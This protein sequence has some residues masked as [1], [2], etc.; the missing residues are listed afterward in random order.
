MTP[1]AVLVSAF[2]VAAIVSFAASSAL[3][4]RLERLGTR[5][6]VTEAILGLIAAIAA[7][8]PEISSAVTA[9]VRGEHT[10]GVG[11]I[12]GANIFQLAALLGLGAVI[13]GRVRVDRRVTVFE[14]I[15]A[16]AVA[17][18]A[19]LVVGGVMAPIIGLLIGIAIFVPYVWLSSLSPQARQ[20][21]PLPREL[22]EDTSQALADEEEDLT[23]VIGPGA[24]QRSDGPIAV[25]ML[26]LVIGASVILERTASDFGA[27][28]KWSPLVVGAVVIA[29][30]TSIPNVVAAVHL[31][32]KGRGAATMSEAMNSNRI[33]TLAGLLVPAVFVG[34]GFAASVTAETRTLAWV[35][36]L[37]TAVVLAWTLWRR[38]VG[39]FAGVALLAAY[40]TVVVALIFASR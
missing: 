11:V 16:L 31:A 10:V 30:V 7:D 6:G 1:N 33:N 25:V 23:R 17:I 20:R 14:G 29:I 37:F 40:V 27:S 18:V 22:R 38:G 13:A 2:V 5:F 39:R 21:V 4:V 19:V 28:M 15:P 26:L 8:A 3:I 35:Y 36:V 32:R 9:V 34:A 12:L 24:S